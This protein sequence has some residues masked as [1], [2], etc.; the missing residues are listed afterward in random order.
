[1][2]DIYFIKPVYV[3]NKSYFV[4]IHISISLVQVIMSAKELLD[5]YSEYLNRT[6][7]DFTTEPSFVSSSTDSDP[8]VSTTDPVSSYNFPET[9]LYDQLLPIIGFCIYFGLRLIG[10]VL[11]W[12]SKWRLF[13]RIKKTGVIH[14]I[15]YT[16]VSSTVSGIFSL[17][18]YINCMYLK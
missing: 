6:K 18:L 9:Q 14:S 11:S 8:F 1:M 13:R 3:L 15:Y 16:M 17:I 10:S 4:E 12:I 2:F 7:S 5:R